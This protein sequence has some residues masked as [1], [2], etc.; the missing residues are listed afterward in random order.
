MTQTRW[1][2]CYLCLS[3]NFCKFDSFLKSLLN[4]FI[5]RNSIVGWRRR[6]VSCTKSI[7]L[8]KVLKVGGRMIH[9]S[10][11]W[12]YFGPFQT[13]EVDFFCGYKPLTFFV[14]IFKLYF[15]LVPQDAS[16][17]HFLCFVSED[18]ASWKK[19][20]NIYTRMLQFTFPGEDARV[21]VVGRVV[22]IKR[23]GWNIWKSSF[24][25]GVLINE[26]WVAIFHK[27]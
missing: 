19:A 25:S 20:R 23:G 8:G 17:K 13:S 12:Y 26:K 16:N 24:E 3:E 6:L 5:L 18:F 7:D 27:N 1:P 9:Q 15:R 4:I 10:K 21:R 11:S 14:K 22:V 2:T